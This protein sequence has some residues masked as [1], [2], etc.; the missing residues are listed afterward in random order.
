MGAFL[1]IKRAKGI[2][3]RVEKKYNEREDVILSEIK[4][5]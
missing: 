1:L 5:N 4:K 2:E 3:F